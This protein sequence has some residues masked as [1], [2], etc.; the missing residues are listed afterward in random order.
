MVKLVLDIPDRFHEVVRTFITE[1]PR[2]GR[3]D[4]RKTAFQR[5]LKD[6]ESGVVKNAL[7]SLGPLTKLLHLGLL[8]SHVPAFLVTIR[9][10]AP[11]VYGSLNWI[12][13][14]ISLPRAAGSPE[15]RNKQTAE[16]AA[17][18]GLTPDALMRI[19]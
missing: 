19:P 12:I 2:K 14:R 15:A 8:N 11:E 13:T 4:H 10:S 5:R 6:S 7:E 18:N 3:V 17:P 1:Y 9:F 16:N